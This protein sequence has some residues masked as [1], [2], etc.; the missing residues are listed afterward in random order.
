MTFKSPAAVLRGNKKHKPL[1]TWTWIEIHGLCRAQDVHLISSCLLFLPFHLSSCCFQRYSELFSLHILSC[2]WTHSARRVQS[3]SKQS[4]RQQ[5]AACPYMRGP[6]ADQHYPPPPPPFKVP[7]PRPSLLCPV[8]ANLTKAQPALYKMLVYQLSLPHLSEKVITTA[9]LYVCISISVSAI[10]IHTSTQTHFFFLS[11]LLY[12]F[13]PS[14]KVKWSEHP[15][16]IVSLGAKELR[17]FPK[18]QIYNSALLGHVAS[19]HVSAS[20]LTLFSPEPLFL[21]Q[22]EKIHLQKPCGISD[23]RGLWKPVINHREGG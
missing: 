14:F 21:R 19:G 10:S 9:K 20:L 16:C 15:F 8:H 22:T 18:C 2:V 7:P 4:V 1:Y 13:P 12:V 6:K 17:A 11:F 5:K 3:E 23:R